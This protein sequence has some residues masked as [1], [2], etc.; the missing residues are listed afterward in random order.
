MVLLTDDEAT[1]LTAQFGVEAETRSGRAVSTAFSLPCFFLSTTTMEAKACALEGGLLV[2]AKCATA[3][4]EEARA[5][6]VGFEDGVL[7]IQTVRERPTGGGGGGMGGKGDSI[8]DGVSAA[9]VAKASKRPRRACRSEGDVKARIKCSATICVSRLKLLVWQDL[10]TTPA[11]QCL[12]FDGALLLDDDATLDSYGLF[13]GAMLQLFIDETV[14]PNEQEALAAIS[15][16]TRDAKGAKAAEDG[17]A[18][19]GWQ[20]LLIVAPSLRLMCTC[21]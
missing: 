21:T 8:E 11:Q 18:G 10:N 3:E 4:S 15:D 7:R 19:E 2:C 14:A 13:D 9:D 6:L 17:F 5:R 12:Y 20:T 1:A 16:L